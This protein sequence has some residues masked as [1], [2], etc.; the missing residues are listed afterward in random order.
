MICRECRTD[1]P[2]ENFYRDNS[3]PRGY[4]ARCKSCYSRK[5]S[6]DRLDSPHRRFNEAIGNAKKRGISFTLSFIE[7][8]NWIWGAPC[9][10]CNGPANGG[11]DRMDNDIGYTVYNV[12]SCCGTCNGM[13]SKLSFHAFLAHT[14][15]IMKN[16]NNAAIACKGK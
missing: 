8:E 14:E 9:Y 2:S 6:E 5:Q 16:L 7:Y 3:R 11:M 12:L 1:Q 13:K 10:Y 4:V 15:I